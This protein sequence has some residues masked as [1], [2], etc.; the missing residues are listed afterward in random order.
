[1]RSVRARLA[2][3]DDPARELDVAIDTLQCQ[4]EDDV[5]ESVVGALGVDVRAGHSK[6]VGDEPLVVVE[7]GRHDH[8]SLAERRDRTRVLVA[9]RLV[10]QDRGASDVL[11]VDLV[12]VD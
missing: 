3:D 11:P 1:V 6:L 8:Q 4:I 10:D 12:V 5:P 9:E 7:V 2:L